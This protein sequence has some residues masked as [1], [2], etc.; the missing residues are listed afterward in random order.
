MIKNELVGA[1]SEKPQQEKESGC[2]FD[3]LP[4]AHGNSSPVHPFRDLAN[5]EVL[6]QSASG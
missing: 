3:D 1:A 2:Q 6:S 4:H 5:R